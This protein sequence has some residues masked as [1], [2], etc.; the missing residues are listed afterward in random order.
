[1]ADVVTLNKS[2]RDVHIIRGK[3]PKGLCMYG[4]IIYICARRYVPRLQRLFVL[5]SAGERGG[6]AHRAESGLQAHCL[7]ETEHRM[8]GS[9]SDAITL[10]E[11]CTLPF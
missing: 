4:Y 1:M 3:I 10:K 5:I 11:Q 8:S 7:Y 6:G 2:E 9:N